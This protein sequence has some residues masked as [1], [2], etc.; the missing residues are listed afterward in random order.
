MIRTQIQL[1]EGQASALKAIAQQ[2]GVSMAELIR[3][4]VERIVEES[5][6]EDKWWRASSLIGRYHSGRSDVSTNHDTYLDEAY[7]S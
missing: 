3:R 2:Q 6:K 1:T 5:D 4:A 7:S